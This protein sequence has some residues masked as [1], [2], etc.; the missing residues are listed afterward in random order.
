MNLKYDSIPFIM[1][2]TKC[3]VVPQT[4]FIDT[5]ILAYAPLVS[6]EQF[7]ERTFSILTTNLHIYS[8]HHILYSHRIFSTHYEH[9]F[10]LHHKHYLLH[11]SDVLNDQY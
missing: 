8:A 3:L 5:K 9:I 10:Y 6:K 7:L 2:Q 4:Q 11:C 1:P